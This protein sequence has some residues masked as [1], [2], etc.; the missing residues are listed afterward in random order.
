M[1]EKPHRLHAS[2]YTGCNA[3][4]FTLCCNKKECFFDDEKLIFEC[5]DILKTEIDSFNVIN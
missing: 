3:V 5:L 1:K 4:A 2:C